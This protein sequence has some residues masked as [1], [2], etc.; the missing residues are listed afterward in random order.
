M[1]AAAPTALMAEP[2]RPPAALPETLAELE[3]SPQPP[4]RAEPSGQTTL[5]LTV[6]VEDSY[7]NRP[8]LM[9]GEGVGREFG[10]FGILDQLDARGMKATLFVNVYEKDR[11]P[12]GVVEEVVREIAARG[13]EVGLHTHPAPG[14]EFYPRPLLHL[15]RAK[16]VEI[17]RWGCEWIDRWT[18]APPVSFRA[19]GYALDGRT[20]EALEDVGIAVD[21]SCFFP[22]ANNRLERFTVNAVARRGE[23][24]EV[25]VT[26]V[27]RVEGD[28]VRHR[29]LDVN[30]L[31]VE[32]LMDALGVI[33][34]HGV[35]FANFMMHSFSFIE[36]ATR[37]V[38]EPSS[39]EAVMTSEH[40]FAHYVD[41]L[42]PSPRLRD[43]FALFLD[44]VA[45]D[46]RLRVRTMSAALPELR[47]VAGSR[48]PD[49]TPTVRG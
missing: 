14:L 19:G 29:K 22:S 27:M 48:S 49:L 10:V 11:Q 26:T 15:P 47:D 5:F 45:A 33:A 8:V 31:S 42:G 17:L 21:S 6:D 35:P 4:P 13:H 36:K 12:A 38:G 25:P 41:V 3:R 44:R 40:V 9:T 43:A 34:D 32:E 18:G 23:L 16:Q 7:F 39:P 28:A 1:E 30:W 2:G 20:F 37:R 24:I 46:P